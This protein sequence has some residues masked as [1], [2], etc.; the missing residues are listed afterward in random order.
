MVV[1]NPDADSNRVVNIVVGHASVLTFDG[2][3]RPHCYVKT[4]NVM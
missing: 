3:R 4:A 2:R 1:Q